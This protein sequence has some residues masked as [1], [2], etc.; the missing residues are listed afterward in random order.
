MLRVQFEPF[1]TWPIDGTAKRK[2]TPFSAGYGDTLHMLNAELGH[3]EAS[4][5]VIQLNIEPNEIRGDG[6]PRAGASPEHPGVI[7][8]FQS[9]FGPLK[10]FCDDCKRWEDNLRA[11]AKTLEWLRLAERYGVSK[12]GEQYAGWRALP[13]P[14]T[15][16]TF[17]NK[18]EAVDWL[19]DYLE[20]DCYRG[21]H[22][23]D[24]PVSALVSAALKK[25]H[26]DH[27]K[28][29][30]EYFFKVQAAR[31]LIERES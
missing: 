2:S 22:E 6:M 30:S 3:L 23:P 19:I 10:Y 11:V 26:P 5:A 20:D 4:E 17:R 1:E 18:T 13:C 28:G 8:S 14:A 15:A 16:P 9:K 27:N 24:A 21:L 29:N 12:R 25:S 31:E 7:F